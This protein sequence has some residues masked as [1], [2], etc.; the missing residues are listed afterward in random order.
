MQQLDC[1]GFK[2]KIFW[3]TGA[4]SGI[5]RAL[6]SQ[7]EMLG[8][9]LILSSRNKLELENTSKNLQ[10]PERHKVVLLDL[11]SAQS[12]KN[13]F[14]EVYSNG[15]KLDYL[16][17]CAGIGHRADA[18]STCEQVDRR[19]MEVNYFGTIRLTKLVLG[20]MLQTSSGQIV[21][22]ASIAG[23]IGV[24]YRSAYCASKHALIGFMDSLRPEVADRGIKIQ[25]VNPGWVNTNLSRNA[26]T[27]NMAVYN[28]T[29]TQ[30]KNGMSAELC[31]QHIVGAIQ[32][33]K[34]ELILAKG[35]PWFG[36]QISRFCPSLFR[37]LLK[38]YSNTGAGDS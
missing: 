23:K 16:I 34:E 30:S 6:C 21:T 29:D 24:P 37:T 36:Y 38:K 8:V 11:E 19:I 17:N 27:G 4:S 7:L 10:H 31:A 12:I 32:S 15:I 26:L 25:V 3:I 33:A 35:E 5:G 22:V 20:K 13:A 2:D 1:I 14:S 9:R 28:K 18:L